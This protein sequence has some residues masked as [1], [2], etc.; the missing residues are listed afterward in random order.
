M[1][2][3]ARSRQKT[4]AYA[5]WPFPSPFL[6]SPYSLQTPAMVFLLL[7]A[8]GIPA[9]WMGRL[10][11]SHWCP[12]STLLRCYQKVLA[13]FSAVASSRMRVLLPI[14]AHRAGLSDLSR[15]TSFYN[16]LSICNL[17]PMDEVPKGMPYCIRM[18]ISS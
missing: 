12:G 8:A 14:R 16:G 10:L 7:Q 15:K 6:C 11:S 9:M 5:L 17:I 13:F 2:F 3:K 18:G 4:L 1:L